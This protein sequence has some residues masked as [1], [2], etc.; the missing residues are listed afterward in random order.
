MTQF[1]I[2][3]IDNKYILLANDEI[4][5]EWIKPPNESDHD[6]TDIN[7]HTKTRKDI[8]RTKNMYFF[9][10]LKDKYSFKVIKEINGF[11][12]FEYNSV[13][14][15]FNIIK[16]KVRLKGGKELMDIRKMLGI[17][18]PNKRIKT[19][20]RINFGKYKG[21]TIAE[22]KEKDINY[23]NWLLTIKIDK[24]LTSQIKNILK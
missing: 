23:L 13:E 14:Y 24:V 3:V 20:Y 11:V 19:E 6:Y 2:E 18:T 12:L 4:L 8:K 1:N 7:W 5:K 17:Y 22:I 21:L 10:E 9:N 15:Y 16:Y